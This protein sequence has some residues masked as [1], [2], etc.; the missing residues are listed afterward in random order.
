RPATWLYAAGPSLRGRSLREH[1]VDELDADRTLADRGGDALDAIGA[2]IAN[3]EHA[4]S[5]GLEQVGRAR[6]PPSPGRQVIDR[7]IWAG[8]D[9][10]VGVEHAAALQ[11][12]GVRRGAGHHEHVADRVGGSLAGPLVQPGDALQ[13][14]VAV[15]LDDLGLGEQLE[16]RRLCDPA[17]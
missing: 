4:G 17:D 1:L 9:E 14:R 6:E 2:N 3:R 10:A 12:L 7:E 13:G 8:L 16:V 5:A 11:Q 15:E